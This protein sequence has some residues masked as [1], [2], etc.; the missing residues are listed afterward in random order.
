MQLTINDSWRDRLREL[1]QQQLPHW[2][3]YMLPVE[4]AMGVKVVLLQY[5]MGTASFLGLDGHGY[6]WNSAEGQPPRPFSQGTTLSGLI[7]WAAR[8]H[9]EL[10]SLTELLPP[11][12]T[13][14][15][16]CPMCEGHRWFNTPQ[17]EW[18]H[19]FVCMACRGLGWID[20]ARLPSS[21]GFRPSP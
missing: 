9:L 2:G 1:R 5:G 17:E 4:E 21:T 18:P 14:G 15:A 3:H 19:G 12:D 10:S 8:A 13:N 16:T 11:P 20:K 7:V 6:W